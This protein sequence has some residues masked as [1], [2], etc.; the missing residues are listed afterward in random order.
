MHE[1]P[2]TV[3]HKPHLKHY[4]ASMAGMGE[5]WQE[6]DKTDGGQNTQGLPIFIPNIPLRLHREDWI[7]ERQKQSYR[8][9]L[10]GY[11]SSLSK[12]SAGLDWVV[13]GDMNR[14]S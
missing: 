1:G 5:V 6:P 10:G 11:Y 9:Q 4:K 2:E 14:S 13:A 12:S 8:S 3:Y 7:G